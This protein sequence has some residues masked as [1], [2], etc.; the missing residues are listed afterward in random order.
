MSFVE[1]VRVEETAAAI[2][3]GKQRVI[4]S[5]VIQQL[6]KRRHVLRFQV[7]AVAARYQRIFGVLAEAQAAGF[8]QH[9]I[10]LRRL[11]G[12]LQNAAFPDGSEHHLALH[13]FL[14]DC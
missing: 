12:T 6:S 8:P 3:L 9:P 1:R 4:D 7:G 11:L 2:L 13:D 14:L 10:S 5:V